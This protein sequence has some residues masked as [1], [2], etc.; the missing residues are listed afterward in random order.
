MSIGDFL[1]WILIALG[2]LLG[3]FAG[4]CTITGEKSLSLILFFVAAIPIVIG[5]LLMDD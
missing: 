3:L 4:G 1:G 2:I 5:S